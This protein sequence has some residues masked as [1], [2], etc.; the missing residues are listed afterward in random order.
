MTA[1]DNSRK[2]SFSEFSNV[3]DGRLVDTESSRHGVNPST[4]KPLFP[5]PVSTPQDVN[6]AITAARKAFK[7]WRK[8]SVTHRKQQLLAFSAALVEH[9]AEFSQLLTKEQG[10]P[11]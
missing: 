2:F 3:I 11:V 6:S 10:K 9:K 8:T 4:S 1:I 7:S 5:C